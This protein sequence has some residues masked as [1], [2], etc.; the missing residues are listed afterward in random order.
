[1]TVGV[2]HEYIPENAAKG[3]TPGPRPDVRTTYC[4]VMQMGACRLD[5]AGQEVAVLN[6]TVSA[7]K[8]HFIPPWLSKMTGMTA[9]KREAEGIPFPEALDKLVAFAGDETP[10]TF[11]GDEHV[12]RGN[13]AAHGLK[14]PFKNSFRLVKP[15]LEG[16]GITLADYQRLGFTEMNSGN[17]HE[18]LGIKLPAIE[19]VG[20]HNALHDAR[21]LTHSIHY[22]TK[23]Q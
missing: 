1:M 18:V 5:E 15:M 12:L 22:L 6:Q 19:G 13:V 20:A 14:W 17:L 8:L 21:S 2:D 3:D 7:H 4:E 16:W 11:M 9:E 10:W 23:G